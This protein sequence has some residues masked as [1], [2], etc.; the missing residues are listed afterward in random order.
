M[1]A[2]ALA[3]AKHTMA[4]QPQAKFIGN[5]AHSIAPIANAV[6]PF[7]PG[8]G[9]LVVGGIDAANALLGPGGALGG[10]S[11]GG[12]P[13]STIMGAIGP[14][15][16]ANA[17]GRG[18]WRVAEQLMNDAYNRQQNATNNAVT[19]FQKLLSQ[20]KDP[21]IAA[22][23][24]PSMIPLGA[25]Q[26]VNTPQI[27]SVYGGNLNQVPQLQYGGGGMPGASGMMNPYLMALQ[28]L[29]QPGAASGGNGGFD[30]S[31]PLPPSASTGTGGTAGTGGASGSST[32]S[33]GNGGGAQS[34]TPRMR[35][36]I[37]RRP[38]MVDYAGAVA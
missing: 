18:D 26:T 34:G 1:N 13:L 27:G 10:G 14:A 12:N 29:T 32:P 23:A 36:P 6:A 9:Q 2:A 11:Q 28:M 4:V 31:F 17:V 25:L 33:A 24:N 15:M 3:V 35:L 19:S 21:A 20:Y 5:I 30:G 38:P 16:G 37:E 7:L 8:V 22:L